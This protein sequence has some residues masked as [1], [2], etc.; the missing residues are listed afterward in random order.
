VLPLLIQ[1]HRVFEPSRTERLLVLRD[2]GRV[3]VVPL[4]GCRSFPDLH[5]R[6]GVDGSQ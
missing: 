1:P 5:D 3:D 6:A 4:E 2:L